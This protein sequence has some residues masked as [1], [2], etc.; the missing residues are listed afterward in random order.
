MQKIISILIIFSF[1]SC[2]DGDFE[3]PSFEF[4]ETISTCGTYVF[5]RTN[6]SQTEA[7]IIQLEETDIVQ[8]EGIVTVSISAENCNY[9]IFDSEVS[10]DYFCSS[11]PPVSPIVIRN[12]EAVSG[13]SNNIQISTSIV[14]E[15]DDVTINSYEHQIDLYNLV[16][17]SQGENIIYETYSF[18]SFSTLP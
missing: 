17:E 9:R 2:S 5:Y 1:F 18:G 13:A 4:N 8:E 7:F 14:F 12:W 3:V 6:S 16:L 10:S 11:I 15:E